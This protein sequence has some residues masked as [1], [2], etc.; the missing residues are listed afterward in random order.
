MTPPSTL[1]RSASAVFGVLAVTDLLVALLVPRDTALLLLGTLLTLQI[2][3]L[4]AA[5]Q[6]RALVRRYNLL[7]DAYERELRFSRQTIDGVGQAMTLVNGDGRISYANPAFRSVLGSPVQDLVGQRPSDLPFSEDAVFSPLPT[8]APCTRQAQ[9]RR[10]DGSLLPVLVS[11]R[12]YWHRGRLVGRL[13]TITPLD[14]EP[15]SR[16]NDLSLN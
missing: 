8:P 16:L 10:P 2:L 7:R 13:A 1:R 12:P 4:F 11:D 5:S 14:L 3:L 15:R 9:V 6:V